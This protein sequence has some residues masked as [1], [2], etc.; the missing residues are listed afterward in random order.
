MELA[1][2]VALW[3]ALSVFRFTGAKLAEIFRRL[4]HDIFEQ[5]H[6]DPSKLLSYNAR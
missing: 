6:L 5:L 2:F 1:A 4:R 3:P